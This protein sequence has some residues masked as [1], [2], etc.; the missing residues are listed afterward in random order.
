MKSARRLSALP[1]SCRHKRGV[2]FA[3]VRVC[4][5]CVRVVSVC[6]CVCVCVWS[7]CA[8]GQCVLQT[9]LSHGPDWSTGL[10]KNPEFQDAC[11][12]ATS[13]PLLRKWLSPEVP[14]LLCRFRVTIGAQLPR[15][16]VKDFF[17]AQ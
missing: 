7:A 8:C 16:E 11:V 1:T 6:V 15:D 2:E 12:S 3:V 13:K 9:V 14:R 4:G 10:Q 5:E 17:F